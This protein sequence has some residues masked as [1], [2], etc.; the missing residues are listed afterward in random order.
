MVHVRTAHPVGMYTPKSKPETSLDRLVVLSWKGNTKT[1]R[2]AASARC[3]SVPIWQPDL[4]GND[5]D[6]MEIL[7]DAVEQRQKQVA[8]KYV[9][10]M[11]ESN[12]GVCNDIPAS[13]LEPKNILALFLNEDSDDGS[14]GKLSG[15]Q[16]KIWFQEV[17]SPVIQA[18][19]AD[20]KGWLVDGFNMTVEQV[21]SLEQASNGYRA[22]MERLAAPQPKVDVNTAKQLQKAIELLG[23]VRE[24][25]MVARKLD[26]KL[27]AII[28]PPEDKVVSLELL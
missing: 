13:L 17:L 20:T 4:S 2:E 25:D 5:K 3:F 28:N 19:I 1:G 22:T 18:K 8:H 11:L 24:S 15:E 27:E 14:R 6:F 9:S 12:R 7:I 23:E 10:E 21:K 26:R 16:I